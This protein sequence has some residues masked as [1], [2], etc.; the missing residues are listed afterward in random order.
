[1]LEARFRISFGPG[2]PW[3]SSAQT[4]TH[5]TICHESKSKRRS[6]IED[7]SYG[8]SHRKLPPAEL[9]NISY[10]HP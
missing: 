2:A 6:I 1:L 9:F 5:L 8:G 10:A 4:K 3:A 7:F